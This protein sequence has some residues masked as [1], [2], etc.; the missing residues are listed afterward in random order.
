MTATDLNRANE[1]PKSWEP[2]AHERD[3][4]EG[5]VD[6]GYFTADPA[7]DKPAYSIMLPPPNVTGQLHMGHA[8]DHTLMDSLVRRKRMQGY[9]VLWLPG[10]DHAGIATQTKVEAKLKAEEG[11]DRYD[12]GRDEFID[13]VWEWKEQYGG[14]ITTQMRAIGDSVDWSRERF[15][16]DE[17]LSRAVQTIFK[18]LYDRGMV[19]RDYRLVNWSPVLETAVSDIEVVYK[20]VEGE[21]VSIRYGS[22]NDDEPHLVVA[23]TRVETML[24]DVAIA[25]HPDDERYAHLVGQELDHPFRD[26]LKLKI[27]A[28]DY[29]DMEFGTGVVKVTPAH[30][31][32]DYQVGVR[33]NLP[34]INLFTPVAALNENAPERFQG[35]DRKTR[36]PTW[37]AT[38]VDLIFGSQSGL[39]AQAEVYG[40]ADGNEKFVRDF[41]KAWDKVMNL[42]RFDI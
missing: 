37:T 18:Q 1:L 41:A 20:D 2:S 13:R 21:F 25:V 24:G 10:M 32:N 22:L 5:W 4:Y 9:E 35:L 23:T 36:Q 39:R 12:Y 8:L 40:M 14:T 30:D 42:D 19:Y 17:G 7:S 31:F 33:H 6:A 34:M 3:L 29:V 11:K 38:R 26:D 28:D 15:T 27:I 16:L